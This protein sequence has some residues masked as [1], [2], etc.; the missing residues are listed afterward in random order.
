MLLCQAIAGHSAHTLGQFR[1]ANSLTGIS[2]ET[3]KHKRTQGEH[4]KP[5]LKI[6]PG[7]LDL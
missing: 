5:E 6:E 3:R 4:V 7:T 2:D 1:V